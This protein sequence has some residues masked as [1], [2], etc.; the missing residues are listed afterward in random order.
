MIDLGN[1]LTVQIIQPATP[2][3]N[4]LSPVGGAV[5]VVPVSGIPGAPGGGG[6]RWDQ[7]IPSTVWTITHNLGRYPAVVTVH[8]ADLSIS[9]AEFGVQHLDTS[10]LRISMDVALAGTALLI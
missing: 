8:S 1:G 3:I 10:T 6:F 4:T 7:T 9:Y 5:V 2:V